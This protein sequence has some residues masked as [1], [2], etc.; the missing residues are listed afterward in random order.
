M[1]LPYRELDRGAPKNNS[2]VLYLPLQ[3]RTKKYVG[4]TQGA[5]QVLFSAAARSS[6]TRAAALFGDGFIFD[7]VPKSPLSFFCCPAVS[8]TKAASFVLRA[9]CTY[10][11]GVSLSNCQS[12][13]ELTSVVLLFF[14]TRIYVI[15]ARVADTVRRLIETY[16]KNTRGQNRTAL[17]IGMIRVQKILHAH[18]KVDKRC[19]RW[20]QPN[21]TDDQKR[22]RGE[23]CRV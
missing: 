4:T 7:E 15:C 19:V 5:G 12:L 21:S 8:R 22:L 13:W 20:T 11:F 6:R 10:A 23:W 16:E 3:R 2:R 17:G 18:L 14:F 9:C 1:L